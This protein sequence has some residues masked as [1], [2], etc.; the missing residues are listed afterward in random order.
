MEYRRVRNS[1]EHST[2]NKTDE[3]RAS[4]TTPVRLLAADGRG[5]EH[6]DDAYVVIGELRREVARLEEREA[7]ICRLY[8]ARIRELESVHKSDV[9]ML[10]EESKR[11]DNALLCIRGLCDFQQTTEREDSPCADELLAAVLSEAGFSGC[12]DDEEE[13][14]V[15]HNVT[16][17]DGH[18][19]YCDMRTP[20][21]ESMDRK[22]VQEEDGT[23]DGDVAS[24]GLSD[25]REDD[26]IY[27]R[28]DDDALFVKDSFC[29]IRD[30]RGENPG[31]LTESNMDR[32]LDQPSSTFQG[33]AAHRSHKF[34][35]AMDAMDAR[36]GRAQAHAQAHAQAR[37]QAQSVDSVDSPASGWKIPSVHTRTR[38]YAEVEVLEK[39]LRNRKL[40]AHG[41]EKIV[42]E[43]APGDLQDDCQDDDDY[44]AADNHLLLVDHESDDEFVR[45]IK[46]LGDSSPTTAN[47]LTQHVSDSWV[48]KYAK[49]ASAA[50]AGGGSSGS[51]KSSFL[52][53]SPIS[54]VEV[55]SSTPLLWKTRLTG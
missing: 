21:V 17:L 14:T 6:E 3:F 49:K 48:Q 7:E 25:E 37:A 11:L 43:G 13:E 19:E 30:F 2:F 9:T 31:V 38:L 41:K 45:T 12:E 15:V 4:S 54:L 24:V 1:R 35:N 36:G 52:K 27:T 51:T 34:K 44:R 46:A 42:V 50:K 22:E 8:E 33:N 28:E 32:I 18:T 10:L 20:V 53:R 26:V 29:Q 40:L 5:Y 39:K 16:P 47:L 23:E 55:L